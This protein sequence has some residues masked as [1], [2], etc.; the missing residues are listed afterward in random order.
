M[1][2]PLCGKGTIKNRKDKMVCCDG[3]KPQKEGS[4]WFNTG[5]CDFHIPYNQKAFGKQLTKNEMNMLL[6]GQVLKNKKGDTL[7]LDLE[8]PDFFTKI[9]FAPRP[10]DNDFQTFQGDYHIIFLYPQ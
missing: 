7:T 8:N 5:E 4:E 2:C 6:N 1:V 10:E 9:D 3:Y